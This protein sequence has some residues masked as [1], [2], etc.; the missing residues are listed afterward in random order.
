MTGWPWFTLFAEAFR[1]FP[2]FRLPQHPGRSDGWAHRQHRRRNKTKLFQGQLSGPS[3]FLWCVVGNSYR[4]WCVFIIFI[5]IYYI[6][7]YSYI[8]IYTYSNYFKFLYI[9]CFALLESDTYIRYCIRSNFLIEFGWLWRLGRH[10]IEETQVLAKVEKK[11]FAAMLAELT[12]YCDD[13]APRWAF[14]NF[15]NHFSFRCNVWLYTPDSLTDCTVCWPRKVEENWPTR[16]RVETNWKPQAILQL[17]GL[18]PTRLLSILS[19]DPGRRCFFHF[20]PGCI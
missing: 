5:Y 18:I 15:H 4:I 8:F 20:L 9:I 11:V 14:F 3:A 16:I 6:H 2:E 1:D 12:E 7:I 19:K 10:S 17:K 13:G